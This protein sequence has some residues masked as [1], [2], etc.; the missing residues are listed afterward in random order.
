MTIAM[1]ICMFWGGASIGYHSAIL[2]IFAAFGRKLKITVTDKS[3]ESRS[4]TIKYRP[5]DSVHRDLLKIK[6]SRFK[7]GN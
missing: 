1:G 7:T 5:L 3:G 4:D 2:F 6:W